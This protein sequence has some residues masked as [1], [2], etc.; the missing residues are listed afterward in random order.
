MIIRLLNKIREEHRKRMEEKYLKCFKE[1][2]EGDICNGI[3]GGSLATD[4]LNEGCI[5]CPYLKLII[6]TNNW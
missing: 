1:H 6:R 4:F 3:I 2:G 5:D